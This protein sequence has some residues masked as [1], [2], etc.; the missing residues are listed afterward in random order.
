MP[1]LLFPLPL[2]SPDGNDVGV[3]RMVPGTS[4]S[5]PGTLSES[6]GGVVS[7]LDQDLA[8]LPELV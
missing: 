8:L 6:V 1:L 7:V 5:S 3:G 2:P 4:I